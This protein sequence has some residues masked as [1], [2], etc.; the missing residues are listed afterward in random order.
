[1][2]VSA[3]NFSNSRPL[4][5]MNVVVRWD[6]LLRYFNKL[7]EMKELLFASDFCNLKG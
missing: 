6:H 2:F 7:T 1:M 5:C 3:N 4:C